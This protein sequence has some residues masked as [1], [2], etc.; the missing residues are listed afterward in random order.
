VSVKLSVVTATFR[1][2]PGLTTT[3]TS[4]EPL[5][6]AA[7]GAIEVVVVDGGT[8][9]VAEAMRELG[10]GSVRLSSEPDSGVYDAMNRGL[11]LSNG[12]HVWFLNGGDEALETDW[13]R[14]EMELDRAPTGVLLF[15]HVRQGRRRVAMLHPREASYIWHGLP[16]N[17]QAIVYPGDAARATGYDLSYEMAG[18]YAFTAQLYADGVA[19]WLTID[20]PL[21][22]FRLGGA[23]SRNMRAVAR[24]AARVQQEILRLPPG[25]IAA[26][27]AKHWLNRASRAL[28]VLR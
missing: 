17:H 13:P 25:R 7:R 23:S 18:D 26:S 19:P 8:T 21:A 3:L 24:D 28:R 1:D 4:L 14:L 5:V 12:R 2:I 11:A 22:R 16:A 27:Q 10:I 9:G 15:A 6:R 20:R